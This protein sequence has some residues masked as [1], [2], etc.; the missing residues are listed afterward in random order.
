MLD[1]EVRIKL[2]IYTLYERLIS[3]ASNV[4]IDLMFDIVSCFKT[5][6]MVF[7]FVYLMHIKAFKTTNHSIEWRGWVKEPL[8][9]F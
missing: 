7:G 6:I 9:C 8:T 1:Y 5:E 2:W 3:L 4:F